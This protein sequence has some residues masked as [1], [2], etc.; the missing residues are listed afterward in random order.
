VDAVT[1]FLTPEVD[2][3]DTCMTLPEGWPEGLNTPTIVGRLNKALD[4]LKYTPQ[5]WH[6]DNNTF[7]LSLEF[8]QSLANPNL[9]LSS[10]G[11]A[12]LLYGDEISILY[13][14]DATKAMIELMARLL[15]KYKMTNPS[16][17]DQ[18]LGIEIHCEENSTGI[19][20]GQKAFITTIF[21]WFNMQ[22]AH[23]VSTPMDPNVKLDLAEDW[24]EK[25]LK[26]IKGCQ[27]IVG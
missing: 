18:F 25:E 21:K 11:I 27:A 15:G 6:N 7:L 1:A 3:D 10:N 8:T 16:L 20:L 24:G 23:N 13:P 19:G 17:A 22:N 12:M 2:D 14:E 4:G 9:S 26:D 5:L